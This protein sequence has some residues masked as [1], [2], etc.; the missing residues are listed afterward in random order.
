MDKE[1]KGRIK[2]EKRFWDAVAPGYDR[3]MAADY[4]AALGKIVSIVR[5]GD[6]VLDVGTGTGLV[7]FEAAKIAEK[8]YGIDISAK[9]LEKAIEKAKDKSVENIEFR[10]EDGYAT[11]F[12]DGIFD[13]VICCNTLHMMN[14]PKS[15]LVEMRRLLKPDGVLVAPTYC[16]AEPTALKTRIGL[17]LFGIMRWLSILPY[18]HRFNKRN[19]LEIVARA[20]FTVSEGAE[21][22]KKALF[23]YVEARKKDK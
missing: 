21:L 20:G 3:A 12:D 5:P 9:M 8:V 6:T 1:Q 4:E 22:D 17:R 19:V 7:A 15:A 10:L 13:V 11:S 23:F 2:G 16:H 18:L 14:D